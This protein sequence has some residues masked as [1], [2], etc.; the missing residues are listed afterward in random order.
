MNRFAALLLL[1]ACTR[2]EGA[3]DLRLSAR[4]SLPATCM[5]SRSLDMLV[6]IEGSDDSCFADDVVQQGQDLVGTAICRSVLIWSQPLHVQILWQAAELQDLYV[7]GIVA[8]ATSEITVPAN[9]SAPYT[10]ITLNDVA[11]TVPDPEDPA[12]YSLNCDAYGT[13]TCIGGSG[14]TTGQTV[15]TCTNFQEYCSGSL[16]KEEVSTCD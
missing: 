7:S 4:L 2:Y 13:N 6:Q 1:S 14:A 16:F 12:R 3:Q 5:P 8:I 11:R 10:D 9:N 15:D